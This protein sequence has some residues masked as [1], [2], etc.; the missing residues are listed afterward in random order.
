MPIKPVF[1][2]Y[3]M[4]QGL[5]KSLK[6]KDIYTVLTKKTFQAHQSEADIQATVELYEIIKFHYLR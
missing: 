3:E 2:V 5:F 6:L 1:D 4:I